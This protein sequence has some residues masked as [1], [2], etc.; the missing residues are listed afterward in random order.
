MQAQSQQEVRP[1]TA[2]RPSHTIS[3]TITRPA[4]GSA[5]HQPSQALPRRVFGRVLLSQR[6]HG[7]VHDV[8]R[9][10]QE[11]RS[12]DSQGQALRRLSADL[13]GVPSQP[14]ERREAARRFDGR[15][16]SRSRSR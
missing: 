7:F 5:H 1:R 11:A 15:W 16:P 12:D 14:P 3:G 10:H 4:A 8:G 13:V 9:E 2:S 6:L